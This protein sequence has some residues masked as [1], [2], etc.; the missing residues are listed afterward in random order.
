MRRENCDVRVDRAS[1]KWGNP[2][3]MSSEGERAEVIEKHRR[4]LWEEV[5]Q[6][7][8]SLKELASLEGKRL[9]CWCHPKPCHA[10]TLAKAAAW[11]K[12]QLETAAQ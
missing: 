10:D 3:V 5:K 1:K 11:A 12:A 2:F 6:K 4:W 9:G 8:V 7:R